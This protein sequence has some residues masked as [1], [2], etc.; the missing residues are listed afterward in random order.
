MTDCDTLKRCCIY[1]VY[2]IFLNYEIYSVYDM[3]D[4]RIIPVE[5]ILK[6]NNMLHVFFFFFFFFFFKFQ[7]NVPFKI[8][9]AHLRRCQSVGGAK[10][11]EPREKPPDTPASRACGSPLRQ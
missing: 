4:L 7:F 3:I 2:I 8:I 6:A 11:G 5:F 1:T 10:T 9:S